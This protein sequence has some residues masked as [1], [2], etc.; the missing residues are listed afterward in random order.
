MFLDDKLLE[1][2]REATINIPDDIQKL[3]KTL[4]KECEDYYKSRIK[5]TM[6]NQEVKATF[7]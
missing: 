2:C 3:N 1:I 6:T 4:C 5:E 7:D